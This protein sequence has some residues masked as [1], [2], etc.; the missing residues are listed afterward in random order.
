MS[1]RVVKTYRQVHESKVSY[2]QA[3]RAVVA[4]DGLKG[5]FGR[6]LK[7]RIIANGLQGLLFSILWKLFLD[8]YV[9]SPKLHEQPFS[10][11]MTQV[12][13]RDWEIGSALFIDLEAC[14][15]TSQRRTLNP[16]MSDLTLTVSLKASPF[17]YGIIALAQFLDIPIAY[18]E[19]I[20]DDLV[21]VRNSAPV[22][23]PAEITS[24]LASQGASGGENSKV[25]VTYRVQDRETDVRSDWQTQV[26]LTKA[27][28]LRTTTGFQDAVA[29]FDALDDHLAFRTFFASHTLGCVDLAIWGAI[30]GA[31][32]SCWSLVIRKHDDQTTQ[33][34]P[35]LWESSSV[36]LTSTSPAGT[37]IWRAYRSHNKSSL[38]ST[39]RNRRKEYVTS[40]CRY[41][42][43]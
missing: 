12:E 24:A 33:E 7:T 35:P 43:T 41:S 26:F 10:Y 42:I 3:A 27:S 32:G 13:F 1:R 25:H 18:E 40:Q 31:Q 38:Q 28:T 8:L 34:A 16:T 22:T 36:V 11:V 2:T 14:V 39:Q 37:V 19:N 15:C 21:L 4:T 6:G 20:K 29:I 30:K 17:P 9:S 23:D 5:L